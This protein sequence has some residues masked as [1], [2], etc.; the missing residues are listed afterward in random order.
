MIIAIPKERREHEK[1][2]AATPDT[3]KKLVALGFGVHVEK[4]AGAKSMISDSQYEEAGAKIAPDAKTLYSAAEII[5]KVQR[6]LIAGEGDVDELSMIKDGSMLIAILDP[7]RNPDHVKAYADKNISAYAMEFMPRITR[8]QSMDVL[9]SQSN[10][11][12]YAAVINAAA[13]FSRA[14]PM[15]MT[16]AGTIA[17]AKVMVMGVGV[18]GLQAIATAKRLGAVVSATD[19]R[20]AAKEQVESLGAK[21]VMVETDEEGETAAGYAKEMSDDYKKR[22]AELIAETLK[23]QDIAITTALIPGRPAPI[24]IT[25][26]MVASMKAGSIIVDLAVEAG[27]NCTLSKPGEVVTSD[28]GVIIVGHLNVPSQLAAD[29]SALYSKNLLN[30][31][32]P[33]A[34]EEAGTLNIDWEDEIIVGTLLTKDKQIVNERLKGGN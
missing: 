8:A 2:V 13:E 34:G 3:V 14:F 20:S 5:F 21:F 7:I 22:Q 32:T 31:I 23:K 17:P 4:N 30:F 18:A 1:R 33:L 19:V 11:S 12:G 28:N 25:D 27:G 29:S 15:M 24:L 9:S 16:A 26:E 10:L 6:P